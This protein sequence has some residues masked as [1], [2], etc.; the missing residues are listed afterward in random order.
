VRARVY[1]Q[2]MDLGIVPETRPSTVKRA[3]AMSYGLALFV[4]SQFAR[5]KSTLEKTYITE[6]G[7]DGSGRG[8]RTARDTFGE[9]SDELRAHVSSGNGASAS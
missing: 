5:S 4:R 2:G 3:Y 7:L 8:A 6:L 1:R 9:A